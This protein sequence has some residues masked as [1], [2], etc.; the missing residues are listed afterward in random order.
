MAPSNDA[1]TRELDIL[2]KT[3]AHRDSSQSFPVSLDTQGTLFRRFPVTVAVHLSVRSQTRD[4]RQARLSRTLRT[5]AF[6]LL[7]TLGGGWTTNKPSDESADLCVELLSCVLEVRNV[8]TMSYLVALLPS[9]DQ[10]WVIAGLHDSLS[11]SCRH[12]TT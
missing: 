7:W 3:R 10:E 4:L 6:A 8:H 5:A 2:C 9:K 11:T 1:Q 12:W